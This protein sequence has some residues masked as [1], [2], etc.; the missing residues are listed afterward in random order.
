MQS[1]NSVIHQAF[2]FIR[3]ILNT[4]LGGAEN[5]LTSSGSSLGSSR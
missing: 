1:A 3:Q 2:G 4:V 5:I